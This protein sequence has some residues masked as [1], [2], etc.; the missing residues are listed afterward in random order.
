MLIWPLTASLR[1][2]A[3]QVTVAPVDGNP[4]PGE[5]VSVLVAIADAGGAPLD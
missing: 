1:A 3:Q 4:L 5:H 2:F